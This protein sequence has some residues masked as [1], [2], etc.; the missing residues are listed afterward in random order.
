MDKRLA[1]AS[2][3][4]IGSIQ[5][6]VCASGGERGSKCRKTSGLGQVTHAL[7]T[8]LM[9]LPHV[10]QIDVYECTSEYVRT[11]ARSYVRARLGWVGEGRDVL[12]AYVR[13]HVTSFKRTRATHTHC[14]HKPQPHLLAL[15]AN[16]AKNVTELTPAKPILRCV[17][18]YIRMS[19]RTLGYTHLRA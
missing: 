2:N 14:D 19:V 16:R 11:R 12:R 3:E 13:M 1:L 10:F 17:R 9:L 18:T 15:S 4:G 8:Y 7:H 5:E 6:S